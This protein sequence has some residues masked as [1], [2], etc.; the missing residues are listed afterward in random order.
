VLLI[1]ARP[2]IGAVAIGLALG[3][4]LTAGGVFGAPPTRVTP[5]EASDWFGVD[6]A[7][8]GDGATLLVGD[9]GTAWAYLR[10]GSTWSQQGTLSS[11]GLDESY[12]SPLAVS[13]D[14]NT[15]LVG[16][17]N[18]LEI[19]AKA[20]PRV[21][22][23]FVRSRSSWAQQA[24][25]EPPANRRGTGSR[26]GSVV[27]LSADGRTAAIGDPVNA[28]SAG[29]VWVFVR[30]AGGWV[31]QG[32]KLTASNALGRGGFGSAISLSR[33]GDTM[34]IG[35]PGDN[36][37]QSIVGSSSAAGAA[38]VFTRSGSTW[39][40][41]QKLLG[42]ARLNREFG[43]DVALT[44]GGNRALVG[45]GGAVA[46][47]AFVR[48]GSTWTRDS[49]WMLMPKPGLGHSNWWGELAMSGDGTTA[50][51][52]GHLGS[53]FP[54]VWVYERTA[55]GWA[56]SGGQLPERGQSY[57]GHSVALPA[58]G[59]SA[60]VSSVGGDGHGEGSVWVFGSPRR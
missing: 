34:L 18:L 48:N 25:L 9:R 39:T 59:S 2:G 38:W 14:G 31:Q 30:R 58:T 23:V 55:R 45:G 13:G 33:S 8:S 44:L 47:W 27:A 20:P 60:F 11:G 36:P 7:A 50:L 51:L 28:G 53:E 52:A 42:Q 32:A 43:T 41:G 26:F 54:S 4:P 49:P 22:R 57:F 37:R 21:V 16:Q 29:A 1:V 15:A 10:T 35:A 24:V 6:L 17:R 19:T 5:A 3:L 56:Q 12:G 46:A 40:Q